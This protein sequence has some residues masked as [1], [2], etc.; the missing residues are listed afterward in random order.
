MMAPSMQV[1]R[2]VVR[3]VVHA[4]RAG[5]ERLRAVGA[6]VFPDVLSVPAAGRLV[7][8]GPPYDQFQSAYALGPSTILDPAKCPGRAPM[9]SGTG[10]ARMVF[11]S[12]MPAAAV[13][14]GYLYVY[15][16]FSRPPKHASFAPAGPDMWSDPVRACHDFLSL[17]RS[18]A[19]LCL[20]PKSRR[21]C[22][23]DAPL[24]RVANRRMVMT[25][26]R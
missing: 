26:F 19:V 8:A 7:F 25:Q 20:I 15:L 6:D 10:L 17:C 18:H 1:L 22:M 21:S 14:S 16:F 2:K 3:P 9:L 23:L 4:P 13:L 5:P 12:P 24:G 11:L